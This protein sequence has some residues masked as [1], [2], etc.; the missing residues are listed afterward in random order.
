MIEFYL[1]LKAVGAAVGVGSFLRLLL[2]TLVML[3]FG[4]LGEAGLMN[5][6]A[7]FWLGMVGWAVIIYEIFAGSA[8]KAAKA[9]NPAV[10]SAFN[11]MRLIVLIGW[12]IYPVGYA[13]G[14]MMGGVEQS[15]LNIVYNLADFVN[16]I[17]FGLVIWHLAVKESGGVAHA[18]D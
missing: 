9:A 11:F 14:Y 1:I 4:Y 3:I 17:L 13:W 12:A 5:V 7:A 16:K 10:A 15:A 6:T 18:E 8:G 2:G